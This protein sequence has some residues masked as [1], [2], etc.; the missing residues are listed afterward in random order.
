MNAIRDYCLR[1]AREAEKIGYAEMAAA[2]KK[3]PYEPAYDYYSALQGI[4]IMH[5]IACCY[6]GARD[7]AFGIFDE[8]MLPFYEK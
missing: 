2:L 5:M 8:Y 1:Y 6:V 7:Y 4:W 3:V